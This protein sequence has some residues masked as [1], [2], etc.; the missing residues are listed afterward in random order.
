L[1]ERLG[2]KT[3][4]GP[5]S[6]LIS[7]RQVLQRATALGL[8]GM[9]LSA[10]PVA[11]RL[12]DTVTP[13][14]AAPDVADGTLQAF[15]D[16]VIPGRRAQLTDLGNEIHPK[17]IAGVHG[18]PGAV[19]V[20]ALALFHHRNIGFDLLEPAF[21]GELSSRA[22][23]RGGQF[24]DLSFDKRVAVCRDG[25]DPSNPSVQMWE[26]AAAVPFAAFLCTAM[27]PNATIDTSSSYQVMGHPGTAPQGYA[28]YSYRRK[29]SRER[30]GAGYLA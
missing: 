11:E 26:A 27:Q 13:A 2:G 19:E 6:E 29:L 18:E 10:L 4:R 17:A 23:L 3:V 30:T 16:T 25:F 24:L 12:L 1:D 21:L 5:F 9:V 7:R 28:D 15:A 22:L 20:D 8:G 14:L